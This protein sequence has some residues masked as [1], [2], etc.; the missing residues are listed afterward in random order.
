MFAARLIVPPGAVT[1]HRLTFGQHTSHRIKQNDT[2]LGRVRPVGVYNPWWRHCFACSAL[3]E[4]KQPVLLAA[5]GVRGM[6]RWFT[7]ST[8]RT[9]G[10]AAVNGRIRRHAGMACC[11]C[12]G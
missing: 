2:R 3:C 10:V 8:A 12:N 7:T 4:Q 6:V 5:N 9:N 1:Q 11:G